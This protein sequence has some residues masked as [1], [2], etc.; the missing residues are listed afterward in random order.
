MILQWSQKYHMPHS[1]LVS[2]VDNDN[3]VLKR[4]DYHFD[5]S[6][7]VAGGQVETQELSPGLFL[8]QSDMSFNKET[9][10]C[11]DYP[12]RKVCQLSFC[13]NG[14]CEWDYRER[15]GNSYQLSPTECS[16]QYGVL[17]QCNSCYQPGQ[18][19]RT[20]SISLGQDRFANFIDCLNSAHL[21]QQDHKICTKVFASTP[22]V[23]LILQQLIECPVEQQLRKLYLEG[24]VLE[25]LSVFCNEV[26]GR[27]ENNRDISKEDYRCMLQARELIDK[28]FLHP[29]TITQIAEACFLSE[30]KLKQGFKTCFG[31]TVYEYIVEKRMEMAYHLLLSD[32]YKVK[33]IVWMVGYSNASHFAELFRKRYGMNPSDIT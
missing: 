9:V 20:L 14:F 29:L 25:L 6:E 24:K 30:T 19:Y 8:I 17:S 10:F 23:R 15:G 12:K 4:N 16:L 26:I 22:H 32:K 31:C 5:L 28:Q 21:L 33:D 18:P 2:C 11:E 3:T 7:Q 13:L 27:Q 1:F